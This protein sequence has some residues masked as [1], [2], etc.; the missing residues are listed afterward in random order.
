ME[1][2]RQEY[3]SG[4]PFPPPG[5]L[6]IPGME[7]GSPVSF[8]AGGFFTTEPSEKPLPI[9]IFIYIFLFD[10]TVNPCVTDIFHSSFETL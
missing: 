1:F 4:L 5:D 3:W 9:T 6:P 2:S 7:T 10:F 8:I